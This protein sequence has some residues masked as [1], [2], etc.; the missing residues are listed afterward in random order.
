[1]ETREFKNKRKNLPN[2]HIDE[3]RVIGVIDRKNG[4]VNLFK[5]EGGGWA[6]VT[7]CFN[8]QINTLTDVLVLQKRN[9]GSLVH[10]KEYDDN[11]WKPSEMMI[12]VFGITQ[13][14]ATGID[15]DDRPY[16]CFNENSTKFTDRYYNGQA[17]LSSAIHHGSVIVGVESVCKT[18]LQNSFNVYNGRDA[19]YRVDMGKCAVGQI[20]G[21]PAKHRVS[22][23]EG[24]RTSERTPNYAASTIAIGL[25]PWDTWVS[26]TPEGSSTFVYRREFTFNL[27]DAFRGA[28][29]CTPSTEAQTVANRRTSHY[30]HNVESYTKQ[31]NPA[32]FRGRGMYRGSGKVKFSNGIIVCW[33]PSTRDLSEYL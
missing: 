9:S 33:S 21:K 26:S 12:T 14:N 10:T 28:L 31:P 1:M 15:N 29:N 23:T 5:K 7:S 18:E 22:D 30:N 27:V 2:A 16:F 24:T 4:W 20:P 32:S 19:V 8:Q 6:M 17:V 11:G 3:D 25:G 13:E